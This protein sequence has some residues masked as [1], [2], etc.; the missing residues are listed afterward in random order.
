MS[1][2]RI[3]TPTLNINSLVNKL[4]QNPNFQDAVSSNNF[5]TISEIRA[6][7]DSQVINEQNF[8]S[9]DINKEGLWYYDSSD[10]TSIDNLGTVL[11]TIGGKRIK[12]YLEDYVIPEWFGAKG[13]GITNDISSLQASID[14]C[15]TYNYYVKLS[16]NNYL[17][18]NQ[19]RIRNVIIRGIANK[20][21]IT[22]ASDFIFTE[23]ITGR[24]YSCI[25]N[26]DYRGDANAFANKFELY[27]INFYTNLS[28]SSV[29]APSLLGFANVSNAII[30]NCS[31]N[32]PSSNLLSY[33]GIDLWS[34]NNNIL[35]E[36]TDVNILNQSS[37]GGAIW[38]RN[39]SN[40]GSISAND[41]NNITI[42]DCNLSSASKDEPLAVY[43]VRGKT[44]NV[45]IEN[46]NVSGLYNPL[47]RS[48]LVSIFPL[49]DGSPSGQYA[50]VEN[51]KIKGGVFKDLSSY[52]HVL[53]IGQ[54]SDIS[55]SCNNI[56]LNGI[57][58]NSKLA[59]LSTSYICR[60]I[61]NNLGIVKISNCYINSD[62]SGKPFAYAISGFDEA[63][64]NVIYGNSSYAIDN[65]VIVSDNI[66][67]GTTNGIQNCQNI[68][69][70]DIEVNTHGIIHN[71]TSYVCSIL[72]NKI[73]CTDS[74]SSSGGVGIYIQRLASLNPSAIVSNNKIQMTYGLAYWLRREGTGILQLINNSFSASGNG[75][76]V[77]NGGTPSDIISG[78]NW[79][80]VLDQ[81]RSTTD[82][83]KNDVIY[84]IGYMTY[85][86]TDN[87]NYKKISTGI[88]KPEYTTGLATL[89]GSS[90]TVNNTD[91][92]GSSNVFFTVSGP[93]NPG[94]LSFSNII[95][96]TS[97][98]INST[99]ATDAS[100]VIWSFAN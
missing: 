23:T 96:N 59:D 46:T 87:K 79:N 98:K 74:T 88:W 83:S 95:N 70:N 64:N 50:S 89:T 71:S 75:V 69:D 61:K 93:V 67:R 24:N 34:C 10:T 81:R 62:L 84:P 86:T 39:I 26:N 47:Q 77:T 16:G 12:R 57:T 56:E 2:F 80:S 51:I 35:I 100:V 21:R 25:F 45:L 31:V 94:F 85:N 82:I 19:L 32:V 41:N 58:I 63:T 15:N 49:N 8:I 73:K 7:Y 22:I 76:L 20:T 40:D 3:N 68:L 1:D 92:S 54:S 30:S 13:D 44:N 97:F 38:I 90:T 14:F 6:L 65:C 5:K 43:G 91:I 9:T 78:N 99:S 4:K 53:R 55:N 48:V 42:R 33:T 52:I 29:S 17:I 60:N 72:N 11:V 66:I 18:K 28:S 27:N 37:A 36:K